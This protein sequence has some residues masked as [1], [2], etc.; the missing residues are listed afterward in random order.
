M[1][2]LGKGMNRKL[3]VIPVFK[4]KANKI[5]TKIRAANPLFYYFIILNNFIN[6]VC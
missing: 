2:S 1:I 6:L 4:H 5:K 3:V